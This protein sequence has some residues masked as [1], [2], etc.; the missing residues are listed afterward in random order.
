MF[1]MRIEDIYFVAGRGI[2]ATGT[3]SG[4]I[5]INDEVEI[6]NPDGTAVQSTIVGV[7]GFS[8]CFNPTKPRPVG[9]LLRGSETLTKK[10]DIQ[11]GAYMRSAK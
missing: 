10:E 9:V 6:W 2:V 8:N 4:K 5:S 1:E 11:R 7:E 3:P